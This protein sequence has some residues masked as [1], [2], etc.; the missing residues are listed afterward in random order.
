MRYQTLRLIH[1]VCLSLAANLLAA[2]AHAQVIDDAVAHVGIGAGVA[3]YNPTNS[4]GQTS[5]GIVLAY[6]WKSFHSGWGPSF[7]L[8]WHSTDFN[9]TL[10]TMNAPFGT[11]RMRAFLAGFGHTKKIRRFSTS[12][13]ISA[14]YCFNNFTVASSAFP[15][16]ASGGVSLVT[17]NVDNSWVVRPNVAV[18]YDVLS[19]V[20]V[21]VGAAYLVNRP[22]QTITTAAGTQGQH[23]NADAFE[24]TA[25]V[26]VGIWKKQQ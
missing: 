11:L 23:L 9:Q 17:S 8:D 24:V 10:G 14:G 13:N 25:G 16:F 21:G 6:R 19:H 3:F 22:N 1:L 15:T 12:E 4:E 20:G 7:G 26:T 2:N 5:Q 18:W